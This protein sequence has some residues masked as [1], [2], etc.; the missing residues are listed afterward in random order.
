MPSIHHDEVRDYGFADKA[1]ALRKRT[2]LTQREVADLLGVSGRAIG[3]WEGGLS[4]PATER[5]KHLIA[6]YL[7]CGGFVAGP[8]GGG[9][10]ARRG[11]VHSHRAR[12]GGPPHPAS[13]PP[14]PRTVRAC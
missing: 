11:R 4:Y 8:G 2:G 7:E 1:L 10:A 3:A 9:A 5:L 13:F 6:L 14:P 12:R